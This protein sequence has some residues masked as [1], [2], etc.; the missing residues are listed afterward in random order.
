[1]TYHESLGVRRGRIFE[2]NIIEVEMGGCVEKCL[3]PS[4]RFSFPVR[5]NYSLVVHKA[6]FCKYLSCKEN[7]NEFIFLVLS[8]YNYKI[9]NFG[10]WIQ[11]FNQRKFNT[12]EI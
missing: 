4:W 10:F 6:H 8:W 1:M 11:T 2:S 7:S 12:N 9:E 3:S 5:G